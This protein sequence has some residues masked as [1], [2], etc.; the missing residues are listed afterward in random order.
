MRIATWNV[1]SIKQRAD[2]VRNWLEAGHADVLCLQETKC[3][4]DAFPADVFKDIG[5]ECAVV[6]QRAYNGVAL[7][8]KLGLTDVQEGLP[9]DDADEQARLIE[10][11]FSVDGGVL[12][13]VSLYLPNGNPVE[14]PK[15]SFKLSWMER[16]RAFAADRLAGDYNVIPTA[17]DC[18]DEAEWL[19]DALYR[20]PTRQAFRR[21][22]NLGLTDA[23]RAVHPDKLS[24]YSFFDYQKGRWHRGEGIRID[25]LLLSP[26]A[27]DRLVAA[28]IDTEP[29]GKPKASDHTP[30]W[31]ELAAAPPRPL[32]TP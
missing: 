3:E 19:D 17:N 9:G 6:G 28:G 2:A 18:W 12:R 22:V 25:H 4:A 29:R 10:A 27:A 1:N 7:L 30:V 32:L 26:S 23:F 24:A 5:F 15:F 20:L 31:C 21:I 8:S 16:L 11:V 13:V 14:T